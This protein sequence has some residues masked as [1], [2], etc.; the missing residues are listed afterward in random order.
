MEF[1]RKEHQEMDDKVK[2]AQ[3]GGRYEKETY[4]AGKVMD[5]I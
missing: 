2:Y 4:K 3:Y 1:I 5:F